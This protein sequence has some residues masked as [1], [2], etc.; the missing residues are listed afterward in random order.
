MLYLL[1]SPVL[2]GV[3]TGQQAVISTTVSHN[4]GDKDRQ[5]IAMIEV[6]DK[7]GITEYLAWQ[8]GEVKVGGQAKMEVSWIPKQAGAYEMRTFAMTDDW[9]QPQVLS[10]V[11]TSHVTIGHEGSATFPLTVGNRTFDISYRYLNDGYGGVRILDMDAIPRYAHI[12]ATIAVTEDSTFEMHLPKELLKQ[13]EV[14][15]GMNYRM[16]NEFVAF[17]DGKDA[18]LEVGVAEKEA[19]ITVFLEKGATRLEVVGEIVI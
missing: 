15:S 14:D 9:E 1:Y 13:F 2:Q 6:R 16:E 11:S 8:S 17:V 10:E 5:F 18:A 3:Q 7:S 4:F 19:I 12:N